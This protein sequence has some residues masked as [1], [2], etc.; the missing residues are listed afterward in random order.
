MRESKG[1]TSDPEVT[2]NW[3][4]ENHCQLDTQHG[5]QVD[6]FS[7][8]SHLLKLK[9]KLKFYS[10]FDRFLLSPKCFWTNEVVLTAAIVINP[11]WWLVCLSSSS[12]LINM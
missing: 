11:L 10:I 8:N 9:S 5:R 2:P 12:F 7:L 4:H 1:V 3:H 6:K